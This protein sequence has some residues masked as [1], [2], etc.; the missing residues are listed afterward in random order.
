MA[1]R[2]N[3]SSPLPESHI[4]SWLSTPAVVVIE[5][6]GNLVTRSVPE[7]SVDDPVATQLPL[8]DM[9]A[10]FFQMGYLKGYSQAKSA[11]HQLSA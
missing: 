5:C 3:T 9:A 1:K 8:K 7:F 2:N 4:V 11:Y 6:G 10:I